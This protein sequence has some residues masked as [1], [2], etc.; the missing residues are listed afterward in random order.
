MPSSQPP[1]PQPLTPNPQFISGVILAAGKS[2]RMGRPKQLLLL[3]GRPLLQHVID[4]AAGSGLHDI[5]LVLGCHADEIRAAIEV[6]RRM[7]V[8]VNADFDAGQSSSL[9][10]GLEHT[11]SRSTAAAILLSDQPDVSTD[12]IDR[13]VGTFT[14]EP[15]P[16]LRPIFVSA[17][18]RIPGHPVILSRTVWPEVVRLSGDEGARSLMSTHPEWVRELTIDADAPKDV[19][20]W[21]DYAAL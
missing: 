17:N 21:S 14:R 7:R 20:T 6:P 15:A 16:I 9:R 8:V 19:D 12:L 1:N 13:V 3:R 4:A 2:T 11:D 18:G 5:V 10:V